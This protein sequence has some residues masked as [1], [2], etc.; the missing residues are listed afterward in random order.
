MAADAIMGAFKGGEKE[1]GQGNAQANGMNQMEAPWNG[2]C[3]VQFSSFYSMCLGLIV[4]VN[5][6]FRMR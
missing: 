3:S 5:S 2:P 1:E 6:Y 4:V